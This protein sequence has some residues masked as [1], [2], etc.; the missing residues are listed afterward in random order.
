VSVVGEVAASV[1]Q[2][3]RRDWAEQAIDDRAWLRASA[4]ELALDP[5]EV[6]AGYDSA[7]RSSVDVV[8]VLDEETAATMRRERPGIAL[9]EFTE[10]LNRRT[11]RQRLLDFFA[12][13]SFEAEERAVVEVVVPLFRLQAPGV[14]GSSVEYTRSLTATASSEW[15]VIVV[16]SGMGAT[17]EIELSIEDTITVV[18]DEAVLIQLPARLEVTRVAVI[19]DGRRVG[20]G[21]TVE[22]LPTT[23]RE[24]VLRTESIDPRLPAI[25]SDRPPVLFP[26]ARDR[27]SQPRRTTVAVRE[28]DATELTLGLSA[29][30][31]MLQATARVATTRELE[32]AVVLPT[33]R[34][35]LLSW[36]ATPPGTSWDFPDPAPGLAPGAV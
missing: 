8:R 1:R 24:L 3:T 4:V 2:V 30:R 14:P 12:G 23:G 33:G 19:Q 25:R 18:G 11:F 13:R 34:D 35:Y 28:A 22:L 7:H 31:V 26:L 17:E 16:G 9:R 5:G 32:L 21:H 27:G 20:G 10:V 15:S 36:Y 29:L 6:L